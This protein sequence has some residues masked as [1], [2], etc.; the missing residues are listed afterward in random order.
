VGQ[1]LLGVGMPSRATALT[2][3][4]GEHF[5]A[6]RLSNLGYPVALTRGGSPTVDLM[7]GDLSGNATLSI[8]VKTSNFAWRQFKRK[9]EKNGWLWDVGDKALKLNGENII[10][11]FVDLK[12]D[13]LGL[14]DVFLV[15]S[16]HVFGYV[17]PE[18]TRYM[19]PLCEKDGLA[20][21][22]KWDLIQSKL[23]NGLRSPRAAL[24]DRVN[25][26]GDE[27]LWIEKKFPVT[28]AERNSQTPSQ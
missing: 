3:A 16:K 27:E 15:E 14:P 6:Y 4:A 24:L 13:P 28:E 23:G 12:G 19:F 2:G 20:I 1:I 22:N 17:K 8:Q 9:P 10:Y 7:V 25:V 5:V 21:K 26:D 11:A 18:H